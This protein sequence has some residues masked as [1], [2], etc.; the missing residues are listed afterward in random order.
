MTRFNAAGADLGLARANS[1]VL[2]GEYDPL[3]ARGRS[4]SLM[5]NREILSFS[6]C[7]VQRGLERSSTLVASLSGKWYEKVFDCWTLALASPGGGENDRG[8]LN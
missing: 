2:I 1:R 3:G 8:R 7:L 5:K 6:C 4:L